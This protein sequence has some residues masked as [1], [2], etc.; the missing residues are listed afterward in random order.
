[1]TAAPA[2]EPAEATAS[3]PAY[4]CRVAFADTLL[5]L[6]AADPRVVAVCNDSVGSSNLKEFA[7]RHPDRLVNV[8]IAEQTMVGVGAG[9]AGGGRIP[10]VC[11][12]SPFL[13][14]RALEQIK[15]DVAYSRANVK[16]CGMS[17]GLAYGQL[18]PTHHSIE[19]LAWLRALADLTVVVPADPAETAEAVRWAHAHDGPVFLRIGRTPVPALTP[20]VPFEPGRAAV[21]RRGDDVTL[22]GLGTTVS[23]LTQAADRLALRGVSARVLNM[24]TVSPL[25]ERAV[26]DAAEHTGGI[27]TMEEHTVRGGLGGAIAETVVTHLPVPMRILGVPGVFAPTGDARFLHEHFHI[28]AAAAERAAL[29]LL[30]R[31]P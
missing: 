22:V 26:R 14:G 20:H 21:L 25:D 27:V 13:T 24:S 12:A 2:S 11:A 18:G 19:D 1:M 4:D 31:G 5:E 7:A 6:A 9:L 29:D 15:A 3:P 10:F 30:G 28:T 8:G 17:P 16:L 23:L